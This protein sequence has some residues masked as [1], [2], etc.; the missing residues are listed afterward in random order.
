MKKQRNIV[1][2]YTRKKFK[3]SWGFIFNTEIQSLVENFMLKMHIS[4]SAYILW[5]E[6][7]APPGVFTKV[8]VNPVMKEGAI[9]NCTYKL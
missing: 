4:P 5:F 8:E 3:T 1:A 9:V 6:D 2:I 7:E